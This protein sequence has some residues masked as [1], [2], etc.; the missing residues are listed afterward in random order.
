MLLGKYIALNEGVID[1][2]GGGRGGGGGTYAIASNNPE[3]FR[4][5]MVKR[6]EYK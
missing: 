4:L 6:F 5:D 2:I 1:L 3:L